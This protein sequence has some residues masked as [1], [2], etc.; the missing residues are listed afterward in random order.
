MAG[1]PCPSCKSPIGLT[2]ELIKMGGDGVVSVASNV[3]PDKIA[4]MVDYA[5]GGNFEE[6]E[7]INEYLSGMFG[8]LFVETN[9]IPVKYVVSK[10]GL[11]EPKYRM[12]LCGPSI[13]AK[14]VLDELINNYNLHE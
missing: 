2:L 5:L 11:C 12:P 9:P 1:I 13:D 14:K 6:A 8:D 4:E 3:V 7:K 10:L